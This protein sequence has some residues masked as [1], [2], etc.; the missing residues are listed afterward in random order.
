[1]EPETQRLRRTATVSTS[2]R[3]GAARS[4][5][6]RTS[7]R[8]RC[9]SVPS[10][11]ITLA[12]M[13]ASTTI[14]FG[15]APLRCP[16]PLAEGR[17]V[18]LGGVQ[19]GPAPHPR[20]AARPGAAIRPPGTAGVTVHAVGL[21]AAAQRARRRGYLVQERSACLHYASVRN[22]RRL[23]TDTIA[24]CGGCHCGF[25]CRGDLRPETGTRT[26]TC[27]DPVRYRAHLPAPR[28]VQPAPPST[29]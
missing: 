21:D 6:S 18:P 27:L 16:R 4:P 24:L 15:L 13:E 3:S 20:W 2:T 10:S 23:A 1:M 26:G 17:R 9:P 7:L 5:A 19:C 22:R 12:R 25:G 29:P 28:P 8:A 11:P 14:N